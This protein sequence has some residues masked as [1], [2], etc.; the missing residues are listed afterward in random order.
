MTFNRNQESSLAEELPYW[1]F[2]EDPFSHLCL[3]DGSI[4]RA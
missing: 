3:I 1:D 2:L 4:V